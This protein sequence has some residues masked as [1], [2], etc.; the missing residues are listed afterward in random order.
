MQHESFGCDASNPFAG[1]KKKHLQAASTKI[2]VT[3]HIIDA[4]NPFASRKK[5]HLQ[6]ASTKSIVT[7]HI[8]DASN[9]FAS[10]KKK[11]LQ[12]AST[13]SIV[14]DH[15]TTEQELC[16]ITVKCEPIGLIYQVKHE[17]SANVT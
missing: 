1:T 10:T 6:A 16:M 8:I 5:K 7:A 9:P 3:D 17:I 4:S 15:I 14:T 12:V 13:K 2:I 11:H